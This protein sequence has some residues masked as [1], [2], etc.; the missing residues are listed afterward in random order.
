MKHLWVAV[1]NV[2]HPVRGC[3]PAWSAKP[4]ERGQRKTSSLLR[5]YERTHD[6][7]RMVTRW[8]RHSARREGNGHYRQ[9][10]GHYLGLPATS[11]ETKCE[12]YRNIHKPQYLGVW[13]V[14]FWVSR[15]RHEARIHQWW[16]P[17]AGWRAFRDRR[18]R[19]SRWQM[20]A[21]TRI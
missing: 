6:S 10:C 12:G 14:A 20:N 3:H 8:F 11:T 21:T 1:T 9:S 4:S 17:Y 2:H 16:N 7:R 5:N 18:V 15:L 19:P 13:P